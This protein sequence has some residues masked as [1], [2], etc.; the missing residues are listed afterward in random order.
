MIHS[1]LL[2]KLRNNEKI[3]EKLIKISK[4]NLFRVLLLYKN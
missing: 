4:I 3:K 1:F 2:E